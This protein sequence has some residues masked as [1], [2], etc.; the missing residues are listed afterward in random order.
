[1]T[2]G[3]IS[4]WWTLGSPKKLPSCGSLSLNFFPR[5]RKTRPNFWNL[6]FLFNIWGFS[7]ISRSPIIL[8]VSLHHTSQ[9]EPVNQ[10]RK[11]NVFSALCSSDIGIQTLYFAK[12]AKIAKIHWK[13]NGSHSQ[14]WMKAAILVGGCIETTVSLWSWHSR[15]IDWLSIGR[16]WRHCITLTQ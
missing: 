8:R 4:K 16:Q 9:H 1:M 5:A 10:H 12:E 2:G 11:F 6:V 14:F 13:L 3:V 7:P 15:L